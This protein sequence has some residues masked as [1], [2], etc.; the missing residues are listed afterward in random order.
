MT[1]V[2][3]AHQARQVAE[4]FGAE[5][6]R[7][8]RTRPSYP[9][10]LV[11]RIVA[12]I[13]GREV[14]DV[15]CG[16]GILARQ[17]RDAGCQVLGVEPDERMAVFARHSGI[18]T[19][20]AKFEDWAD[21]GRRFDAVLAGTA[22]HWVDPVAGAAKAARILRPGGMFAASWNAFGPPERLGRELAAAFARA[23]G[24]DQPARNPLPGPDAYATLCDKA[25]DALR[26]TGGFGE[27]E[28]WRFGWDQRYTRDEFLDVVPTY[29]GMGSR[30]PADQMN[31][32]LAATGAAI[33]AFGGAFTMRYT[34]VTVAATRAR[35][36]A[37]TASIDEGVGASDRE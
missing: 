28:Q 11:D 35:S 21:A 34:T 37:P 12:A 14:I 2:P 36:L 15:G 7:Y 1:T 20:I 24:G 19:E 26:E 25:A 33:D 6:E 32:I 30:L 22:W 29:G 13:P 5:A 16:T 9:A 4:S 23:R 27:P 10:A 31:E 18:E 3:E 17:L 8:D